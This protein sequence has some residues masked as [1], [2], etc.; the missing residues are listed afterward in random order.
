MSSDQLESIFQVNAAH[1]VP[2]YELVTLHHHG[3]THHIGKRDTNQ[4]QQQQ[5]HT[6][7]QQRHH[8]VKTDFSKSSYYSEAKNVPVDFD[9]Q[10]RPQI[11]LHALAEHNVSLSA[12]GQSY[13][14]TLRPTQGLFKDGIQAL[15]M[16]T[17]KSEPNATNGLSYQPVEEV[18]VNCAR[19]MLPNPLFVAKFGAVYC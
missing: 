9:Q 16:W 1:L 12:F 8:H 10:Q 11:D 2:E 6:S 14:L 13:N 3:S 18:S 5:Q 19:N 15:R 7:S 4:Q 17:V